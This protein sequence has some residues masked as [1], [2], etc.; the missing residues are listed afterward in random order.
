MGMVELYRETGE[1][2]YLALAQKFLDMRNISIPDGG[3]D[4]QDRVPF[5]E[6]RGWPRGAGQLSLRGG[7]RLYAKMA[8]QAAALS[9]LGQS[10]T[11]RCI[12]PVAERRMTARRPTLETRNISAI[13][14]AYGRNYQLYGPQ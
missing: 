2:R 12:S 7:G 5:V 11:R 4:N 8:T 3:D 1:P 10:S 14:Q 13:H 6:Q 9:R